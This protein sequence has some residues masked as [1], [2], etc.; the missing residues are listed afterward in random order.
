MI[1][2]FFSSV[3]LVLGLIG[4]DTGPNNQTISLDYKIFQQTTNVE[5]QNIQR[6]KINT[7]YR[8]EL[9]WMMQNVPANGFINRLIINF[10]DQ[11]ND[12]KSILQT[13][14][15]AQGLIFVPTIEGNYYS[16]YNQLPK[17]TNEYFNQF[18]I[19]FS[20]IFLSSSFDIAFLELVF[21]HDS[22]D[23]SF[24]TTGSNVFRFQFEIV[25]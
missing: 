14:I 5:V 11:E 18:D 22:Y 24:E 4:C 21:I 7:E 20:S 8:L 1:K 19:V 23:F 2:L 13:S 16:D 12:R 17:H 15:F 10:I 25:S 6:L 9:G 3:V